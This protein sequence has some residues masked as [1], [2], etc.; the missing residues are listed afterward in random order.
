L[1][2]TAITKCH[3]ERQLRDSLHSPS[4]HKRIRN[5]KAV[6]VALSAAHLDAD[7]WGAH[8]MKVLIVDDFGHDASHHSRSA[9]PGRLRRRRRGRNGSRALEKLRAANYG[10]VISDWQM[11]PMTGFD[12]L[13]EVRADER[14]RETP[15]IIVTAE[16]PTRQ[17]RHCSPR[18]RRRM[19]GQAV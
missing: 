7:S 5:S 6:S 8:F 1:R 3:F 2:D 16:G 18:R 10:L 17:P 19:S 14:L 12:L 11:E 13:K 4:Q 15:F 9:A